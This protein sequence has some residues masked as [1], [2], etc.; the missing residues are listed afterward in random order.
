M[1]VTATNVDT[2]RQGW[3]DAVS[4][5]A[6]DI[7]ALSI[8]LQTRLTEAVAADKLDERSLL[9]IVD[10]AWRLAAQ[11]MPATDSKKLARR[12]QQAVYEYLLSLDAIVEPKSQTD[13]DERGTSIPRGAL[14]IGIEEVQQLLPEQPEPAPEP[15]PVAFEPEAA[16]A[17]SEPEPEP[18]PQAEAAL[19]PEPEASA[20]PQLEPE[21]Q[22]EP[23][24]AAEAPQAAKPEAETEVPQAAEPDHLDAVDLPATEQA[25]VEPAV[26]ASA[27]EASAAEASAEV[28]DLQQPKRRFTVFRRSGPRESIE[29]AAVDQE[30]PAF[31][32]EPPSPAAPPAAPPLE[33]PAP[34]A[35]RSG[36]IAPKEGFHIT[37]FSDISRFQSPAGPPAAEPEAPPQ[38]A[39]FEELSAP[40]TEPAAEQRQTK[41][42]KEA[43]IPGATDG[44]PKGGGWKLRRLRRK[45]ET[46]DPQPLTSDDED[47]AEPDAEEQQQFAPE[48][49]F[50]TDP[51]A[52]ELRRQIADR[53]RHRRCDEAAG[54]LQRLS[55]EL[56]GREVAELALDAGDRCRA[57]GKT[58]AAL[59]CY[60]AA[61]RADPVHEPPLLRL[62]DICLDDKD[63]D[64]AVKYM[65]RVAR[66]H[67]LRDDNKG[68]I[69][70][71]RKIATVAP[72]REDILNMLMHVQAT[73]R[74]PDE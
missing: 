39:A 41:V 34:P 68:A 48:S 10:E 17:A 38:P 8:L 32:A 9:L 26:E 70:V 30:Q 49:R 47:S 63:I 65:E 71:Y 4:A 5:L 15:E 27:A 16:P 6:P 74:F 37:E 46:E 43:T 28:E 14:L 64:L 45:R 53:L 72:Y 2:L 33:P 60:L 21:L 36:F 61:S 24:P 22:P 69:R 44:D 31:A 66:L 62:A 3:D 55:T 19:P 20:P 40:G 13:D 1:T 23:E 50:N 11:H 35:A 59:S 25:A 51:A 18:A 56:G 29:D 42:V 12:L 57:L 67:R 58:N 54:L 73:G 52:L 7:D